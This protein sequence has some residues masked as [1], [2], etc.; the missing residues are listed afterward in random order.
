MNTDSA[1]NNEN[2]IMFVMKCKEVALLCVSGI[3]HP[4]S[5]RAV[6]SDKLSLKEMFSEPTFNKHV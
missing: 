5:L 3:T 6:Q 4:S 2:I 1:F